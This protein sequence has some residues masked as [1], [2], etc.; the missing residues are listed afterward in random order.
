M[1]T[2]FVNSFFD[3]TGDYQKALFLSCNFDGYFLVPRDRQKDK[4]VY[5]VQ[6]GPGGRG[7]IIHIRRPVDANS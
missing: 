4:N 7:Y 5:N 6:V 1:D 3:P 2:V